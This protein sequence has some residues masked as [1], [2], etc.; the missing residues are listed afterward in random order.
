MVKRVVPIKNLKALH[1]AYEESLVSDDKLLLAYGFPGLGKTTA[2]ADLFVKESGLLVNCL[3]GMSQKALL[4]LLLRELGIDPKGYTTNADKLMTVIDLVAQ[5]QRPLFL[6]EA[7]FLFG[8]RRLFETV[9][10]IHDWAQ[11]P[12]VVIGMSSGAGVPGIDQQIRR[13][14]QFADRISH[15]VKFQPADLEDLSLLASCYAPGVTLKPELQDELLRQSQ[16]NIRRLKAALKRA[17]GTAKRT[18]NFV[19]GLESLKAV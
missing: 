9:R 3:P 18:N 8:D 14:P 12:I 1:K 2:A 5:A 10:T 6:D 19:V 11:V 13:Y 4:N 15:W 17:A 16:G 7:D